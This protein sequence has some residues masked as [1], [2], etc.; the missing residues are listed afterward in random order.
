MS[1]ANYDAFDIDV[2]G[3]TLHVGRWNA[4]ADRVVVAAHGLTGSHMNFEALADQLGDDYTLIAPDLRGRGHSNN[5]T[6]PFGMAAHADDVRAALDHAGVDHATMIGHSMGGFVAVVTADR[7]PDR[8]GDLVL[9]DGGIPL[10]LPLPPDMPIEDVVRAVVG[11][12]L[13]RLRMTFPS[14]EAYLDYWRPHPALADDWNDYVEHT[15]TYDLEGTAPELRP[16]S[17]ETAVL[18]DSASE[19]RS[20]DVERA[21]EHL[22]H[23]AVHVRAER[24]IFNQVPPLY[25]EP[26]TRDG[27]TDV[28]VADVNHYTILLSERGA[29]AVADVIRTKA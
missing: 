7:H 19:L 13:D 24:G 20:G 9:I 1:V 10:D 12:A 11:P 23:P 17:N 25:A 8:V 29:K 15:Y 21:L 16:T 26:V 2:P 14:V 18:E 22:R 3:G 27:V 28:F 5:I 6:G 4:G